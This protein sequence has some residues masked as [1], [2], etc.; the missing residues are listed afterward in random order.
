MS[1]P[2]KCAEDHGNNEPVYTIGVA[3][4]LLKVC[5]ATLRIWERKGL[6][7]PA[8]LGKNRFYSGCDL[9]RLRMIKDMIRTRRLNIEGVKS[10]LGLSR[11]W[12]LKKCP[13]KKRASCMVYITSQGA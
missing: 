7:K 3:S 4:R 10:V 5:P 9:D 13:A 2:K 11:C 1:L 12:E 8:R 6:V